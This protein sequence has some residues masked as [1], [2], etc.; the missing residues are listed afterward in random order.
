MLLAGIHASVSLWIPARD[1]REWRFNRSR[2]C[3]EMYLDITDNGSG[4][5]EAVRERIFD[6]FFT[7]K[8]SSKGAGLGL[9]ICHSHVTSLGGRIE[10]ESK[11][12][13]GTTF[14][15]VLPQTGRGRLED[16]AAGPA[17]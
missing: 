2:N 9:Y 5:D 12:G 17:Q 15:V 11:V 7:T 6:P 14:R 1:M 16:V 8:A 10:V 3:V 4:I 13:Q